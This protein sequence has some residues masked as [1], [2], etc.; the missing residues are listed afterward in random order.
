ME[1]CVWVQPVAHT[2]AAPTETI[3]QVEAE[4]LSSGQGRDHSEI[5]SGN[6]GTTACNT[7]DSS[8]A[9]GSGGTGR[10]TGTPNHAGHGRQTDGGNAVNLG[11]TS[12]SERSVKGAHISQQASGLAPEMRGHT[13][14]SIDQQAGS[15]GGNTSPPGPTS[16][17]GQLSPMVQA[18]DG[19]PGSSLPGAPTSP[20]Q[21]NATTLIATPE[22]GSHAIARRSL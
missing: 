12:S 7:V 15:A 14:S 19:V 13:N 22:R 18:V 11:T 16:R 20:D 8:H 2:P 4:D 17:H 5:G 3:V 10:N 1:S 9:R 21:R 6:G